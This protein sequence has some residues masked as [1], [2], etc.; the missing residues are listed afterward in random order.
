[1]TSTIRVSDDPILESTLDKM[2]DPMTFDGQL[3]I[4]QLNIAGL[5]LIEEVNKLDPDLVIDAGC[6]HNRFK[7]H[8]KNLIGFDRLGY[9]FVDLQMPIEDAPFRKE[10]ADVVMALGAVHFGTR[11]LVEKQVSQMVSWTKPGGFL[12]FRVNHKMFFDYHN[13]IRMNWTLQDFEYFTKKHNLIVYKELQYEH[14]INHK[15]QTPETIKMV[16]W[17]QKPGVR[18]KQTIDPVSCQIT[19]HPVQ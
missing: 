3:N 5:N 15:T 12:I 14:T 6:G 13:N 2:F 4:L 17:W 8:I 16:W 11:E 1:M 19:D 9:P 7:G 18:V 10:S